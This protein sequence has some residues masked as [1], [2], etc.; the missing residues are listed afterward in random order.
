M[1]K[2]IG[3]HLSRLGCRA[4]AEPMSFLVDKETRLVDGELDRA[5]RWGRELGAAS[6]SADRARPP[7]PTE[8]TQDTMAPDTFTLPDVRALRTLDRTTC[9]QLLGTVPVARIGITVNVPPVILPVNVTLAEP[10][11]DGEPVIVIRTGRG[12]ELSAAALGAVVAVEADHYDPMAHVGWSV[13]VQGRSRIVDGDREL[14]WAARLPLRPWAQP[15][16]E[17]FIVVS[18][19]VITGRRFGS[20]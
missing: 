14:E 4:I 8:R 2:G 20:A 1:S 9:L 12:T 6:R 18:T 3:K 13:L 11:V 17:C 19:E 5:E 16:A 7:R 15:G 10:L